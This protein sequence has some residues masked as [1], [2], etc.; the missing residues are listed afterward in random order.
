MANIDFNNVQGLVVR[1]YGYPCSRHLL[2]NCHGEGGR[3]WLRHV[4]PLVTTAAPWRVEK[5]ERLLNVGLTYTGLAELGL[6]TSVLAAFPADFRELPDARVL[7][8]VGS[9]HP[10]HWW[11]RRFRTGEIHAILHIYGQSID[12]L[13]AFTAELRSIAV[14]TGVRELIA[15]DDGLPLEG[16]V[17]T[18]SREHFG[19]RDGIAQPNVAWSDGSAGADSVD[20]RHFVLGYSTP[21]IVST[22]R[23]GA[24]GALVRDS[25]YS[26]FRWMYQDVAAFNRFLDEQGPRLAPDLE[27]ERASELLGAKLVGRWRDGTPLVLSPDGPSETLAGRD[28]FAYEVD[29]RRGLRC[30]FSAHI[31]VMNPRDQ[32]LD[33][34]AGAAAPRVIRRGEVYGPDLSS[35]VDDGRDRGLLGIFICASIDRQFYRLM[36]WMKANNF[37]PVFR[38]TQRVQDA[39]CGNRE[40]SGAS[41]DFH[42][43]GDAGSVHLR[44][45]P[46][47]IQTKGTA[48][49]LLP[50]LSM[51]R[52]LCEDAASVPRA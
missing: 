36:G 46:T 11:A 1:A 9:S 13:D 6:P 16:R 15:A 52:T 48:F 2:F 32:P 43:P 25:S 33:P 38:K 47:F 29:D 5:P 51:L 12:I 8:D 10:D 39:L 23:S 26:V 28:D 50:S 42:I 19:F 27:P 20:F 18:G 40:V 41:A 7:G 3:E 14:H 49:F 37:S 22:P 35:S 4:T 17:R 34:I 30:P 44:G 45:L 31:R 21:K 24:A